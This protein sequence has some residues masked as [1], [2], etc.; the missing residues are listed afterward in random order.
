MYIREVI[1]N[2]LA[3]CNNNTP[4][5]EHIA[6]AWQHCEMKAKDERIA[7]LEAENA[8]LH[9]TFAEHVKIMNS[10]DEFVEEAQGEFK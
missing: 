3:H 5:S 6:I 4:S 7:E 9:K 1:E 8:N 10:F 2:A